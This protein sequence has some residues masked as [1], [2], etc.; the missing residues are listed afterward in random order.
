MH[1]G[2][3][4][5]IVPRP[6]R[7]RKAIDSP[8]CPVPASATE[9]AL[10]DPKYYLNR[11]LSLLE[12]QERVLDE[13]RDGRNRL[14]ERIKFLSIVCSNLDEFFMVRVAALKQKFAA[15]SPDLSIDGQTTAAQLAAVHKRVE[16]L[17][18][19]IYECFRR[20]LLP[21][22]ARHDIQIADYEA[23][24]DRE[25]IAVDRYYADTVSPY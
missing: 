22:L 10:D 11:E 21:G 4:L 18:E 24:N 14:L 25:R 20:Q 1:D 2:G 23:L 19:G 15:G 9:L 16:R 12:F 3:A 5:S 8:A 17:M 13:A 6:R 7:T